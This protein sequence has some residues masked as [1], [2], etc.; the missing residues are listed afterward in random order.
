[1]LPL[2]VLSRYAV[3]FWEMLSSTCVYENLSRIP[4][5]FTLSGKCAPSVSLAFC[6]SRPDPEPGLAP[7]CTRTSSLVQYQ[8]QLRLMAFSQPCALLSRQ[9]GVIV[10]QYSMDV[11]VKGDDEWSRLITRIQVRLR[12]DN[13]VRL[14]GSAGSRVRRLCISVK[15]RV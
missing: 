2:G 9:V 14:K 3:S 1:M 8:L 7:S 13:A 6:A 4:T 12:L 15:S 11:L 5:Q 10:V